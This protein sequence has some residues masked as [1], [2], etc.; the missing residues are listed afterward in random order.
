MAFYHDVF[1]FPV[2][3]VDRRV[4]LTAYGTVAPGFWGP[5]GFLT[6]ERPQ[7][8]WWSSYLPSCLLWW[9]GPSSWS[10]TPHA[11][12]PILWPAHFTW[13]YITKDPLPPED[14]SNNGK[15][16]SWHTRDCFQGFSYFFY[17]NF[18]EIMRLLKTEWVS[19]SIWM[20]DQGC[21]GHGLYNSVLKCRPQDLNMVG[22]KA[23]KAYECKLI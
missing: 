3:Y 23:I 8:H 19:I 13:P 7:H 20:H 22:L 21:V 4:L 6:C 14:T 16:L 15:Q 12:G 2:N 9:S 1:L 10:T 18:Y 17:Q 11:I 5:W